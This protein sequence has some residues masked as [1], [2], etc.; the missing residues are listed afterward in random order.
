MGPVCQRAAANAVLPSFCQLCYVCTC[1]E[2][3]H[4]CSSPCI[5]SLVSPT[6]CLASTLRPQPQVF[7]CHCNTLLRAEGHGHDK[8]RPPKSD[9]GDAR[10][11]GLCIHVVEPERAHFPRFP[12][13]IDGGVEV[14]H[15][16][17]GQQLVCL[18]VVVK[19]EENDVLPRTGFA[20]AHMP[21]AGW[22]RLGVG[23]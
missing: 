8:G 21:S 18:C 11:G 9:A 10:L 17:A 2:V 20:T 14:H 19:V 1:T 16:Q 5:P 4:D 7:S 22:E 3:R 13:A 15:L 6:F 12:C 23:R